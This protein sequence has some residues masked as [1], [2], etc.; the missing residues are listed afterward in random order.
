MSD[1]CFAFNVRVWDKDVLKDDKPRLRLFEQVVQEYFNCTKIHLTHEPNGEFG[2]ASF[3]AITATDRYAVVEALESVGIDTKRY[4]NYDSDNYPPT[5]PTKRKMK[6]TVVCE[7]VGY[8]HPD[9]VADQISDALLDEYLRQ[10][11]NARCGIEA[12]VKSSHV[13][14]SGE[15]RSTTEVDH[16]AVVRRV[17]EDLPYPENHHLTPSE[18]EVIDIIGKQSEE[19]AKAVDV[20]DTVNAGDQ[21]VS[22][23]MA[24]N[25]SPEY[26]P[27]G[28][29]LAKKMCQQ[30]AAQTEKGYGPDTKSQVVVDYD[31][32]GKSHVRSVLV[33]TM[34]QNSLEEVRKDVTEMVRSTFFKD[35]KEQPTIT[36]NPA[37]EWQC[38]GGQVADCGLTG[39]KI[40]VDAFGGY[41]PVGG[42]AFSGKDYSKVD[43]SAAYMA[44]F[45]ARAIV[46][47]GIADTVKVELAYDIGRAKPCAI[48]LEMNRRMRYAEKLKAYI[49]EHIDL[50]PS[51]IIERFEGGYPRNLHLARYGHFGKTDKE[52]KQE[53]NQRLY[54]WEDTT[55]QAENLRN[56][57]NELTWD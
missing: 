19:I 9:K 26:L 57:F 18:I 40:V 48:N 2:I 4:F 42:G 29:C 37:G 3:L 56:Y 23:S 20:D 17:Y 38:C 36:V 50:T 45:I 43:R 49:L 5:K 33:S 32:E 14:I 21:G 22:V 35:A 10:D 15:V 31:E 11:P 54:P 34:H 39:R 24:S 46:Q 51:G 13:V 53:E 30:V 12:L 6:R 25:E 16:E 55:R 27:L 28:A 7:Y 1:F 8:G 44:R 47:A 52:M 41:A